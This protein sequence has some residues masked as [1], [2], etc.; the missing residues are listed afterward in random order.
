MSRFGYSKL[1][2]YK[3]AKSRRLFLLRRFLSRRGST[4]GTA[5]PASQTVYW[6]GGGES[7]SWNDTMNWASSSAGTPGY[8]IPGSTNPV[9]FDGGSSTVGPNK[10]VLTGA[11]SVAA[12]SFTEAEAAVAAEFTQNGKAI[13]CTT[14]TYNCPTAN[15]GEV[16]D[17]VINLSGATF[18]VTAAENADHFGS[19]MAVSCTAN[20]TVASAVA[21]AGS[22]ACAENFT[23]TA[24]LELGRLQLTAAKTATFS[25]G[26]DDFTLTAYTSGD[27][28]GDAS[29]DV[30][31]VSDDS[32][33]WDF[34]NPSS[35]VVSY[36]TVEDSNA[37]NAIDATDNC[38]D[39]T[40]NTNW[41]FV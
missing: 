35:M 24:A 5:A 9:V 38:H 29:D 11:V 31:I 27:W 17:G 8:G 12:L 4:Q 1:H 33:T 7:T 41:T 6:V 16:F 15:S 36:I 18:T 22:F 20:V 13:S 23:T 40:G 34:V 19:G 39:G 10:C 30:T 37:T 28:D 14:F 26:N 32:T 3:A 21:L 25:G 2:K